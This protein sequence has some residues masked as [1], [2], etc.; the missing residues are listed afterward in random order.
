M[1]T[2]HSSSGDIAL[3]STRD[4]RHDEAVSMDS[5]S[6]RWAAIARD[7]AV[8]TRSCVTDGIIRD[9]AAL[10]QSLC[11]ARALGELLAHAAVSGLVVED[12]AVL[13]AEAL[14][15]AVQAVQPSVISLQ[16]QHVVASLDARDLGLPTTE[17]MT[18]P[19]VDAT[20][21]IHGA[22]E[23]AYNQRRTAS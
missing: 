5:W 12:D 22:L 2:R 11:D 14:L 19:V 16:V 4:R 7:T 13:A 20:R 18:L 10:G 21:A 23:Q 8:T 6:H 17:R 3:Q 15:R 1:R 9:G